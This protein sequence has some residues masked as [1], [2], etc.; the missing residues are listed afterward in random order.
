MNWE[1]FGAIAETVGAIAVIVTIAYLAVQ[2]RQNTTALRSSATNE[3]NQQLANLYADVSIHSEVA[4]IF[5]RGSYDPTKLDQFETARYFAMMQRVMFILQNVVLQT[6][7]NLLDQEILY[8]W[9]RIVRALASMPGFEPFWEERKFVL[10]PEVQRYVETLLLDESDSRK[11]RPLGAQ[12][13][14]D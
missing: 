11:Y 3:V 5:V 10:S 13:V 14:D 6:K 2:I 8:S 1:A 9:S 7:D 12:P 4:S